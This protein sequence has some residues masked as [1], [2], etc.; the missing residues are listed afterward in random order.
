[1]GGWLEPRPPASWQDCFA[2]AARWAGPP[3]LALTACLACWVAGWRGT[4]WAAQIYRAGQVSR[5]GLALWDPGWYGGMLPLGYSLV[6]PLAAAYL[7]LWP[8]AALSAAGSALCFD[9]LV[10]TRSR[11]PFGSWYFALLTFVPVAIGQLPTL[12]GEALAL[13][14]VLSLTSRCLRRSVALA[15]GLGLGALA[16]LTTPVAGS[17]LAMALVAWGAAQPSRRAMVG[18]GAALLAVS[19]ALPLAF[20]S[21]GWF[22][23]SFAEAAP[24][25]LIAALLA[26][27]LLRAPLPVRAAGALYGLVTVLLWAVRTPMGDNDARLAA[28]IGIPLVVCYLPRLVARAGRARLPAMLAAGSLAAVLAVWDWSPVLEAFGGATDGASSVAGYYVPLA[29]ELSVLADG[30]P[31]KVEVPPLAHHWESAYLAPLVPLARGWERQLD[32]AYAPIFY[33]P[34]QARTYLDW[35]RANGVSYVA[36]A[37]A[38]LDY[39]ATAEANL[40]RSG[41]AVG[42]VEVWRTRSWELWKVIGSSGLAAA[43]ATVQSLGPDKVVVRFSTPGESTLKLRW[44]PFWSLPPKEAATACLREGRDG[45]TL[46]ASAKPGTLRIGFS[47]LGAGHGSCPRFGPRRRL[48]SYERGHG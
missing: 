21:P 28:Y 27:P 20:R 41:R 10:S 11:R 23:F 5:Y 13:G 29:R 16:A 15:G 46:V 38:P 26:S 32:L 22:P 35:L 8:V 7:G 40:L 2:L 3:T 4:D 9:R 18:V 30:H 45:W 17:F 37:N 14:S 36:L 39:A 19:A 25:V 34:L 48:A 6:F 42:L 43:P 31:V 44:D 1:V 33:R 12:A 47:L 24:V